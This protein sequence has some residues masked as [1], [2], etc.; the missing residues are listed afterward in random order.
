M[1]TIYRIIGCP[2]CDNS[3]DLF[4]KEKINYKDIIVKYEDK[5]KI[6]KKNRKNT[7]PHIYF[8]DI[9]I[10]GFTEFEKTINVCKIFLLYIKKNKYLIDIFNII[11]KKYLLNKTLKFN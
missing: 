11:S 1:F 8:N 10:G 5:E 3:I 4:K 2:Y 6:K 9:Q 7:F